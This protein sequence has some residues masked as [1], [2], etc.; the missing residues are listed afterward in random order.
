MASSRVG[1]GACSFLVPKMRFIRNMEFYQP[2]VGFQE[3]VQLGH[4]PPARRRAGRG[5]TPTLRKSSTRSSRHFQYQTS[6]ARQRSA[7]RNGESADQKTRLLK[8]EVRLHWK[9]SWKPI[10]RRVVCLHSAAASA[11][12][13]RSRDPLWGIGD[14]GV[15]GRCP[16]PSVLRHWH[17]PSSRQRDLT[18][19]NRDMAGQKPSACHRVGGP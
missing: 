12:R 18:L 9:P 15:S 1:G 10:L 19:C 11:D 16:L 5:P 17:C 6:R 7:G 8:R 2:T 13:S 4:R 14:R 3:P